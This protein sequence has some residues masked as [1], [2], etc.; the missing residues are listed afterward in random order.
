MINSTLFC[1]LFQEIVRKVV[2]QLIPSLLFILLINQHYIPSHNKVS[3]LQTE[4]GVLSDSFVDH[5]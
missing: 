1:S 5:L 2:Q 4:Q 3:R